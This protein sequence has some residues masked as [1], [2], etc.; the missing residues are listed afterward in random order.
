[1]QILTVRGGFS[2]LSRA[3]PGSVLFTVDVEIRV[4]T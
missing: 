1:M 2:M 3:I 4:D